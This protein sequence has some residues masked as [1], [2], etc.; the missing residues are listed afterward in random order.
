MKITY[1]ISTVLVA[2][3]ML[4]SG[5]MHITHN[6]QIAT[7]MHSLGYPDY[8]STILGTAKL[9]GAAALLVPVYAGI[10]EWA[11]AGF[12]FLLLGAAASHLFSGQ[13]PFPPLI[14][15][16]FLAVSY[17]TRRQLLSPVSSTNPN[18]Q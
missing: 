5:F 17:W 3:A 16:V 4:L 8:M 1:W 10:R 15:L 13:A 11:Y 2:V 14:V 12:T 7:A 9:L 6:P 18:P